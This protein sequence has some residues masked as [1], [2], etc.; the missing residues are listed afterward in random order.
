M[1]T[2][3]FV[4][5]MNVINGHV[6]WPTRSHDLTPLDYFLWEYVSTPMNHRQWTTQRP[7]PRCCKKWSTI[8]VSHRAMFEQCPF[9]LSFLPLKKCTC[10]NKIL[11]IEGQKT[12]SFHYGASSFVDS[13]IGCSYT[14]CKGT[15]VRNIRN[16]FFPSSLGA[17]HQIAAAARRSSRLFN[18]GDVGRKYTQTSA[19]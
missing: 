6:N 5:Q 8:G 11:L 3:F 14:S 17:N 7:T 18:F 13:G 10:Q 4:P 9:I 15:S 1:I 16:P 19:C 12:T 2:D